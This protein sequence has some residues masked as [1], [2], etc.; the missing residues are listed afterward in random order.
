MPLPAR[1][2]RALRWP[3][4]VLFAAA[5]T[6]VQAA[7]WR[8]R[9]EGLATLEATRLGSQ[10]IVLQQGTG[11]SRKVR[12]LSRQQFELADGLPAD[13]RGWFSA[14]WTDTE[15]SFLTPLRRDTGIVWGF[16]TGERGPKYRIDPSVHLGFRY[17]NTMGPR[18]WWSFQLTTWLGGRLRERSCTAD[19]G[20]I[21][22]VQEVNCRL[23][24]SELPPAETLA[25]LI[26]ER[27]DNRTR[28]TWRFSHDF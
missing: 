13:V 4:L 26:N 14:S 11:Q 7:D 28:I 9:H 12:G 6:T 18:T 24:A 23:A 3:F 19:Y 25:Y 20:E 2:P 17:L 16:S 8:A 21:G 27:P 5:C 15:L 1:P 22:G 10:L